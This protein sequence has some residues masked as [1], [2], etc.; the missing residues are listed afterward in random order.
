MSNIIKYGNISILIN[1]KKG[2]YNDKN[3]VCMKKR[4]EFLIPKAEICLGDYPENNYSKSLAINNAAK[5]A[6][7]DIFIIAD[8]NIAFD[9]NSIKKGIDMLKQYSFIIPYGDLIHLNQHSTNYFHSLSPSLNMDKIYFP[10]YKAEPTAVGHIFIVT[11]DCFETI[12]GF[13]ESMTEWDEENIDFANRLYSKFDDYKRLNDYFIWN[14]F[15]EKINYPLYLKGINVEKIFK[16]KY[17]L[18]DIS[19]D[20][21]I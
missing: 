19:W 15:Y 13:D 11:R 21:R 17:P 10:A 6:T 2:L 8:S 16:M 9:F 12:G 14:L 1:H 20:V 5:K 18:G 3:W 7:G 4:Y